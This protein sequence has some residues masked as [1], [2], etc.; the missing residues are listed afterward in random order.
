MSCVFENDKRIGPIVFYENTDTAFVRYPIKDS[1]EVFSVHK[2]GKRY[3]GNFVHTSDTTSDIEL[4]PDPVPADDIIAI[5]QQ[6]Q[7]VRIAPTYY[8]GQQSLSDFTSAAFTG[9]RFVF[10]KRLHIVLTIS[11]SG[12]VTNVELPKDKNNLSADEETELYR[13]YSKM[14]RW[15]PLF[16]ANDTRPVRVIID[17][18]STLSIMSF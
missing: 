5:V 8:F 6:Y 16:Y 3:L 10:N 7:K 13:I 2:N 4:D 18:N 9:S 12:F 17:N 14:P 11:G 1:I 15:Q